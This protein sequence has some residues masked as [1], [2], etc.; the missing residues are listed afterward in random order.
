MRL[1]LICLALTGCGSLEE[2][3]VAKGLVA[4][5]EPIDWQAV[6]DQEG[7]V[8]RAVNPEGQRPAPPELNRD[9]AW[10]AGDLDLIEEAIDAKD[11]PLARKRL[12]TLRAQVAA[13][14]QRDRELAT[15]S[16]QTGTTP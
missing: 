8:V 10:F 6:D 14:A 3:P 16:R 13:A 1:L 9:Y 15:A 11:A 2:R 7:L 5:H 12:A 4:P